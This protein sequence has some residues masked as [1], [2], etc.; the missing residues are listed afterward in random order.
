[1]GSK[2]KA[3]KLGRNADNGRF[4]PVDQA[5]NRKDAVVEHI[6]KRGYG[7]TDRNKKK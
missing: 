5:R 3:F 1:M 7:D 4:M 2:S 6:P